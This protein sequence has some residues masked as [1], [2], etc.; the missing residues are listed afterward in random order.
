MLI[1]LDT[2][3]ER[4]VVAENLVK[5]RR[6]GM[7]YMNQSNLEVASSVALSVGVNLTNWLNEY[8]DYTKYS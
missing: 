1:D 8:F 7:V 3:I 2:W 6:N 4:M 5:V